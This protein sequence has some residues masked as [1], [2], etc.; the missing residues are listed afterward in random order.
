MPL[1]YYYILTNLTRRGARTEG[2][3]WLREHLRKKLGRVAALQVVLRRG[4][5]TQIQNV[6]KVPTAPSAYAFFAYLTDKE[7]RTLNFGPSNTPITP[8]GSD[9]GP[10]TFRGTRHHR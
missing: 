7:A 8:T 4:H 6:E 1:A 2:R 10:I 3:K 5:E 9:G